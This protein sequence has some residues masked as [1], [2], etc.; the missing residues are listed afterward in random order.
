MAYIFLFSLVF[1]LSCSHSDKK[2]CSQ[3][4][5]GE[6]YYKGK[7]PLEG[8]RIVRNDSVQVVTDERTNERLKERIVWTG[9]CT[10][11]LYPFPRS[12]PGIMNSELFP[13]T[14]RILEVTDKYYTVHVASGDG[15]TD[16]KDTAWIV[17]R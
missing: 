7:E 8:N 10:Y 16:F 13:L 6:F 2:R 15:K 1:S 17:E 9:P 12:K 11:K 5:N 14:V 4:R 3:L